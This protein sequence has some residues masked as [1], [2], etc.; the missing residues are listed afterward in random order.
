[1]TTAPVPRPT[2]GLQTVRRIPEL[3]EWVAGW[4][5]EGGRVGMVPTMG[6]LHAGH[7]ALIARARAECDRV[8]ATLFVNPKQF[9]R[10]DDLDRY[11][12][13]EVRDAAFL[14]AAGVDLLFAPVTEEIYPV[15]FATTVSVSGLTECLCGITRPGHMT[16]VATVVTKLLLQGLPDSAYFG[17]KDYQ[18]LLVVRRLVRDLDIPVDIAGIPTVREDDGLALSSR[19]VGLTTAQRAVAPALFRV[20]CEAAAQIAAGMAVGPVLR[21]GPAALLAAGFESVDYFEL[22][23]GDTLA[24]LDRTSPTARVFAAAWL[25][26]IRLIDNIAIHATG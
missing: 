1:M 11:P 16:G 8:V 20:L 25:G 5:A 13:D 4:R 26:E 7:G 19:N 15:G 18:Q 23:D 6:G 9:N 2:R 12:R 22:R 24:A 10:K 17:E 14:A 3:R 21:D